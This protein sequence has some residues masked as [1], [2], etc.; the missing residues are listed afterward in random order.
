MMMI[1]QVIVLG[2]GAIGSVYAAKLAARH[3]VLLIARR[4]HVDAI[5]RDG[6]R[7][8][9][10]ETLSPAMRA[11]TTIEAI[12][13]GTLIL[14]VTKVYDSR[15]AIAPLTDKLRDD[16]VIVCVQNGLGSEEIVKEQV[17]GRCT[18]LRAITQFGAIFR[19]PGV[20][21]YTSAGYTLLEPG[22]RSA[23]VATLLS[24]SGLEGRVSADI[25]REIWRKLIFNCVI[26]PITAIVGCEVGDI[27]DARL[28]PLKQLVID[29]CLQV[30]HADGVTFD[31]DFLRTITEVFSGA[32]TIASMRQDLLKGKPTE[33]DHMNGAVTALGRRHGIACPVN[34]ALA[35][36][37]TSMETRGVTQ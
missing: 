37:I 8:T 26:N 35:A 23:E 13:P 12:L 18:V 21:H 25:K 2:G 32:R 27:A 7:I 29:E 16:T 3:D 14:L 30:A 15:A 1:D 36:I 11:E 22:A 17:A 33:I 9:G 19:Q 20:V 24:A 4:P 28:D 6:L 10:C 31:V 34:S 5:R